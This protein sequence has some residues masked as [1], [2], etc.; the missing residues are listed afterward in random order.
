MEQQIQQAVEIALSGTA[1]PTLKNQ[2]FE[3]INQI[4]TTPE[5]YKACVEILTTNDLNAIND[6]LKFFIYQVIEEN[7]DFIN[8]NEEIFQL[9]RKM[10]AVLNDDVKNDTNG[11]PIH[12]RNKFAQVLAKI[13]CRVYISIN[14]DFIK[15]L[16]VHKDNVLGVDYYLRVMMAIHSEIGDKYIAR[17]Q[18]IQDRNN[19]LK[20]CI[21]TNDMTAL[22]NNWIE[23]LVSSSSGKKY[24]DDILNNTLKIIG[25]YVGWMEIS[26]FI[27][28]DFINTIFNYLTKNYQRNVTCETLIDIISKKMPPSNKL[29]LISL[30]N[31]PDIISSLNLS[32]D[33]EFTEYASKLI[34]QIG[35][36]L[37]IVL[38]NQP[39][40]IQ[41]VNLELYKIWPS[42]FTFLNHE[43]DDVSQQVLPFIQ[44]F[45]GLCKKNRD[46]Y[47]YELMSTLLNKI[48]IKMKYDDD[49]D[50]GI[51]DD[52][53]QAQFFEFRNKLKNYQDVIAMLEPNLFLETIPVVINQSLF[54][55]TTKSSWRNLELGLYE[56]NNFSD[57]IR[58]NVFGI[59]KNEINQSKP[60]LIFQDFL[61]K[62][63]N[64]NFILDINHPLIQSNF[65]ELVV[66]HYNFLQNKDDL[67]LRILEIFTSPFGLFNQI[68]KVRFRSWY[69]FFR[70]MKLT[71]PKIDNEPLIESM[72]VKLQPLL[73]IKA[74]L[75]NTDELYESAD[76]NFN[77]QQYLFETMGL[78]ISLIPNELSILKS[79][80]IDL[81]FQPIFNDLE[82]CISMN[83][84]N[85]DPLILLQAHHSLMALGTIV[86]GYD[87]ELGLKIPNEVVEKIDNAAQV[88]LITLENFNKNEP[89]RDASR[90]AFARFI[91]IFKNGSLISHHLTKLITLIWANTNLKINELSDFLSFLS[92]VI[93]SYKNDDNIY[94]LLN[95]FLTPLFGKIFEILEKSTPDET[96]R[97]DIIRDKNILKRSLLNFISSI[98]SNHNSS[99]FITETNK[100][101]LPEIITKIFQYAY[102]L[103][104]TS[105]S[106][107]AVTQIINFVNVFDPTGK[108]T[109]Q[110][111]TYSNVLPPVVG[112]S[113]FLIEK[114]INLSFELP[115]TK[116][117]NIVFDLND[118]QYR[119]I[120]Q[121][122]S[123]LL[124]SFQTAYN[125][126]FIKVVSSYLLSM[127]LNEVLVA[128]FGNNLKGLSVKDFKKYFIGFIAGL[129]SK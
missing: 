64:S 124:K 94:Q 69:L 100:Q 97:P 67:V 119:L 45:L 82:K 75:P 76:D 42:I 101:E 51:S 24:T 41:Q 14:P 118:A 99:L 2:A 58:N 112:I 92:Q 31:L 83:N 61:V 38:E 40:L 10:M 28:P 120:A 111:D 29:E 91:P 93:H 95:N 107:L 36:E 98:I 17:S 3:F 80:L 15:E 114:G 106:K 110:L 50:D 123:L 117:D 47:T 126:E 72:V 33:I 4:K 5:G 89:I 26:L 105:T 84:N 74:E 63:I 32:D 35:Q 60:Y 127:G 52:D 108:I 57:C 21:R 7:V 53:L 56:M 65:F 102:D 90:F 54:E 116:K 115:Y 34:N 37:L 18:E 23:I 113:D 109:D 1:D 78:L 122:L 43:F 13:F 46:L 11:E 19:L 27:S 70:F 49:E 59:P 129:N 30:L 73:I 104:D 44:Q 20:D 81:I 12:L 39:N 62:T 77:N 125:D 25:Q 96:D 85:T 86:R 8:D 103:S 6:G 88:V 121:E 128:E 9:N 22:V 48:I 79:K 55:N 16:L 87:Y 71:K 68:E 66:K